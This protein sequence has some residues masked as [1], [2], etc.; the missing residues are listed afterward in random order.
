VRG[1]IAGG[2]Q[3]RREGGIGNH[4]NLGFLVEFCGFRG[5]IV[6]VTILIAKRIL[7]KD[8]L[9]SHAGLVVCIMF[10][11]LSASV[12]MGEPLAAHKWEGEK[13]KSLTF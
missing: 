8:P 1:E 5:M 7:L 3:R 12:G 10:N 11:S 6:W 4:L 2:T 9:F 13:K